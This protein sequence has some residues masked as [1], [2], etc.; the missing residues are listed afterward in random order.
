ML[1]M[2]TKTTLLA[3]SAGAAAIIVAACSDDSGNQQS[4]APVGSSSGGITTTDTNVA[5][6]SLAPVGPTGSVAPS[7]TGTGATGTGATSTSTGATGTSAPACPAPPSPLPEVTL[8][9]VYQ[10]GDPATTRNFTQPTPNVLCMEGIAQPAGENYENWGAGIGLQVAPDTTTPY[11]ATAAGITGVQ[12]D[13][14]DWL[15]RPVRVQMSQINDP[16]ITDA[17]ANFENNAFVYGGSSPRATKANATLKIQFTDFKLPSWTNIPEANQGPLDGS[18]LHSLQVQIANEPSDEEAPYKYC[19]TNVQW[20]DSCGQAIATSTLPAP[21]PDSTDSSGDT[22]S[23]SSDTTSAG[24]DST[25]GSSDTGSDSSGSDDSS[26]GSVLSY[27]ADVQPILQS[28]CGSCHGTGGSAGPGKL[29]YGDGA[30]PTNV[31]SIASHVSD[32]SMPPVGSPALSAD[33]KATILE[34]AAQ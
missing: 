20:L 33:E 22:G 34:W 1:D 5:P 24:S 23:G 3:L 14:T 15:G 2:K 17:D 32:G 21:G 11:N 25:S 19:I 18:K 4:V 8:G 10:Y 12:F 30:E 29:W 13:V 16:A 6:T 27:T 28:K 31:A 9:G 7:P 26:S